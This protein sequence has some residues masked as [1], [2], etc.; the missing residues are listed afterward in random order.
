MTEHGHPSS[1]PVPFTLA[2][3]AG[4]G[5]ILMIL[6]LAIGVIEGAAADSA[7]VGLTFIGGLLL[8]GV[9]IVGWFS[10]V[11]PYAHFDDINVPHYT[12]HHDSHGDSH[13]DEHPALPSGEYDEHA[14]IPHE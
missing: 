8:L 12:G 10:V 13:G 6:S 14:I 9:G 5:L 3:T 4:A 11:Q 1:R 7:I 2:L